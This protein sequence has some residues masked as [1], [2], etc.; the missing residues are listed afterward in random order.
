MPNT[1]SHAYT[2]LGTSSSKVAIQDDRGNVTMHL[3][4]PCIKPLTSH[5]Y[6][7]QLQEIQFRPPNLNYCIIS[8]TLNGEH[9]QYLL[10]DGANNHGALVVGQKKIAVAIARVLGILGYVAQ[11][12]NGNCEVDLTVLLPFD[13]FGDRMQLK[14]LKT[15]TTEDLQDATTPKIED[16][17]FNGVLMDGLVVRSLKVEVEG[18]GLYLAANPTRTEAIISTPDPTAVLMFGHADIPVMHFPHGSLDDQRSQIFAGMGFHEYLSKIG[19]EFGLPD[20]LLAAERISQSV[21]DPKMLRDLLVN[22]GDE[23]ELIHLQD[24]L[25]RARESYW[26]ERSFALKSMPWSGI[27]SIIPGGGAYPSFRDEVVNTF[28]PLGITVASLA[29]LL[30]ELGEAIGVKRSRS[31]LV[32]LLQ[33][34]DVWGL[35]RDSAAMQIAR[36]TIDY[37]NVRQLELN[38]AE[39]SGKKKR[40]VGVDEEWPPREA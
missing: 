11:Q 12:H 4:S 9:F 2:D 37:S 33:F 22:R 20:E 28:R 19:Q 10:G 5:E 21:S 26:L 36:S 30:D 17:Y 18:R 34:A 35:V 3:V 39:Q 16:F 23:S 7:R 32:Y 38:S 25:R 15:P 24:A 13:E 40:S 31:T 6:D 8:Y 1:K 29:P 14:P 27:K